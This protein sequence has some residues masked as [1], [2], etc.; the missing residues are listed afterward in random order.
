V[1]NAAGF[2]NISHFNKLFKKSTG[3]TPGAFR[4]KYANNQKP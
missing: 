3:D 2:Q 1:S 4:K